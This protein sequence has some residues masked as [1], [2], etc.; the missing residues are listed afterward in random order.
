MAHN[1]VAKYPKSLSLRDTSWGRVLCVCHP[2]GDHVLGREER[3]L[4]GRGGLGESEGP[5]V[6]GGLISN[7]EGPSARTRSS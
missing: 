1:G 3:A 4:S 6:A 7:Q 5:D 2:T